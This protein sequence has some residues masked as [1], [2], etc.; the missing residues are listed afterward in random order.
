MAIPSSACRNAV[1]TSVSKVGIGSRPVPMYLSK[2]VRD[3]GGGRYGA[4]DKPS[5]PISAM[6]VRRSKETEPRS[7]VRTMCLTFDVTR[8]HSMR[9][10]R[11]YRERLIYGLHMFI[12]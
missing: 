1:V 12:A 11:L 3:R 8:C 2:E 9:K 10:A 7:A 5:L 4:C 6:G